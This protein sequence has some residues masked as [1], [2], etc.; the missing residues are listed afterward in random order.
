MVGIGTTLDY[1]LFTIPLIAYFLVYTSKDLSGSR[2]H[3]A[4]SLRRLQCNEDSKLLVIH[5]EE[6][7]VLVM[8]AHILNVMNGFWTVLRGF[9]GNDRG[10]L[11]TL[12][13]ITTLIGFSLLRMNQRR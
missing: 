6:K 11:I 9:S 10:G 12:M 4:W 2:L 7:K 3:S 13:L 1:L 8:I 5:L